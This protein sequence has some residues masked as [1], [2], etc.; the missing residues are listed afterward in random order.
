M[1]GHLY[2]GERSQ[3]RCRLGDIAPQ[4]QCGKAIYDG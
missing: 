2:D 3:K 1:T 4:E